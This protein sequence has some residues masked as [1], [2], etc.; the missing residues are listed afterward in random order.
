[1]KAWA[2][3]GDGGMRVL[4]SCG[5]KE[6]K[7]MNT[8]SDHQKTVSWINEGYYMMVLG[9]C[10]W[11]SYGYGGGGGGGGGGGVVGCVWTIASKWNW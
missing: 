1:M 9:C 11:F 6:K 3:Q 10:P 5:S 7:A 8:Q 2:G 4:A